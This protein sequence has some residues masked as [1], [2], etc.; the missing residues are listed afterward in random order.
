MSTC[1]LHFLGGGGG[2]MYYN[3][4]IAQPISVKYFYAFLLRL[5]DKPLNKYDKLKLVQRCKHYCASFFLY[6]KNTAP[7]FLLFIYIP[8]LASFGG[9]VEVQRLFIQHP[10]SANQRL[11][12]QYH[13]YN[14]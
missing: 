1:E 14:L 12:M 6:R 8:V 3:V 7:P 13:V 10:L 4:Y 11:R 5:D 2:G 9:N